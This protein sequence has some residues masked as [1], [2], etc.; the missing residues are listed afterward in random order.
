MESYGTA[1]VLV[2]LFN[3]TVGISILRDDPHSKVTRKFFLFTLFFTMWAIIEAFTEFSNE[4]GALIWMRL[5]YVPFSFLPVFSYF[6]VLRVFG[7]KKRMVYLPALLCISL[8]PFMLTDSFI[9]GVERAQ[10]YQPVPGTLFPYVSTLYLL[11]LIGG[12]SLFYVKNPKMRK[13]GSLRSATTVIYG[14]LITAI[15]ASLFELVSP[16]LGLGLPK[17][18]CLFSVFSVTIMKYSHLQYSSAISPRLQEPANVKDA[19]CGALCSLCSSLIAGMCLGCVMEKEGKR[20]TCKIYVCTR[21]K[22]LTCP[23]CK[24]VLRC[25]TYTLKE[26][27][28]LSN[29]ARTLPYGVSYHVESPAL[30][31]ARQAFRECVIRGDFGLV[32]SREHPDVFF[33][34]WDLE[35]VPLIWL[36]IEDEDR[37]CCNPLDLPKLVY[38]INK[39]IRSV[40]FSCV[41]FE[42]FEYLVIHNTFGSVMELIYSVNDAV[43]QNRCRFI[44]SYDART[45]DRN[46][47]AII[48]KELRTL[49]EGYTETKRG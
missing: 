38:M 47:K 37:W 46:S 30:L 48:E 41:L 28:P 39:F 3:V 7:G 8:L 27:C 4:E 43:V 49:P 11:L 18:G 44:L 14:F 29:P 10:S 23:T 12:F 22:G 6:F 31:P 34:T 40:P 24:D 33:E 19:P 13:M 2:A 35:R 15:L 9:T 25:T 21:E 26:E 36:S 17:V 16:L 5:S 42:G 20:E 45:L 32:V 1:A